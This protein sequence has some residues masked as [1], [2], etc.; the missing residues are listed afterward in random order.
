MTT[1]TVC[2]GS[3]IA[4]RLLPVAADA[5]APPAENRP[6][7][8]DVADGLAVPLATGPEPPQPTIPSN[9]TPAAR[10][11]TPIRTRD[12]PPNLAWPGRLG[13]IDSPPWAWPGG[14]FELSRVTLSLPSLRRCCDRR[15]RR[16][17]PNDHITFANQDDRTAVPCSSSGPAGHQP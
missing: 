4:T 5:E 7:T 10:L 2:A 14:V 15:R 13:R 6:V 17:S 12:R 9:T 11:A 1:T 16:P 3:G 8:A